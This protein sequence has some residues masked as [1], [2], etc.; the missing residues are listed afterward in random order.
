MEKLHGAKRSIC[1][2]N[3]GAALCQGLGNTGEELAGKLRGTRSAFAVP[4]TETPGHSPRTQ[5]Q[6]KH[7]NVQSSLAVE[8]SHPRMGQF[9]RLGEVAQGQ[10]LATLGQGRHVNQHFERPATAREM[11]CHLSQHGLASG[12]QH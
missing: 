7:H 12:L 9:F 6:V 2:H 5:H 1:Q 10:K 4:D 11:L 8:H 3:H